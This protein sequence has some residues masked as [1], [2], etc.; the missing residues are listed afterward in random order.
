MY[1]LETT[2]LGTYGNPNHGGNSH[3]KFFL[4]TENLLGGVGETCMHICMLMMHF[5]LLLAVS[6]RTKLI[7]DLH[8][9]R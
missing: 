2:R 6:Y 7:E 5:M 9:F 4:V 8:E 1:H 3:H